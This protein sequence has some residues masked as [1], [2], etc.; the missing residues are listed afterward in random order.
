MRKL[1]T[2]VLSVFIFSSLMGCSSEDN[3]DE[4]ETVWK[5]ES[6]EITADDN[7]L[8][9]NEGIEGEYEPG[10]IIIFD[11]VAELKGEKGNRTISIAKNT[12]NVWK[13][14]NEGF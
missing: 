3:I 11:V 1:L 7:P 12:D 9:R 6:M 2:A 4:K 5:A 10:E 14:I 8:Y 13:V